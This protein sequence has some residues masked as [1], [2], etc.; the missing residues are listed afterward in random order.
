MKEKIEQAFKQDLVTIVVGEDEVERRSREGYLLIDI[1]YVDDIDLMP[2]TTSDNENGYNGQYGTR[3]HTVTKPMM[4]RRPRFVMA[5]GR[6]NTIEQLHF[7]LKEAQTHAQ[8]RILELSELARE[9]EKKADVQAKYAA[10][11]V[12]DKKHLDERNATLIK[13]L[14]A[15]RAT[16]RKIEL[17]IGKVRKAVGEL[18]MKEILGEEKPR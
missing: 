1:V 16:S 3:T 9:S 18:R 13:E 15:A 12:E 14:E 8:T 17:D 2:E 6:D 7:S 11:L 5:Q 4:A 10:R